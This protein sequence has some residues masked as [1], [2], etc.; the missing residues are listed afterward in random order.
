MTATNQCAPSIECPVF[1]RKYFS[2]A[3]QPALTPQR[4]MPSPT[5]GRRPCSRSDHTS[6]SAHQANRFFPGLGNRS[7]DVLGSQD[8][9][10]A[11][12]GLRQI[13]GAD[14]PPSGQSVI[15]QILLGW[16]AD[17]LQATGWQPLANEPHFSPSPPA[18]RQSVLGDDCFP[19]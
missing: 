12:D 17:D 7:F 6:P 14:H 11:I 19:G 9:L 16:V 5:R 2:M 1:S 4:A 13:V 15:E 10:D 18:A 8:R 3:A